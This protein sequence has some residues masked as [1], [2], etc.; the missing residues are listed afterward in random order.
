M[1]LH[2]VT[3]PYDPAGNGLA[4]HPHKDITAMLASLGATEQ[5]WDHFI[6]MIMFQLNSR[7]C[8]AI[9]MSPFLAMFGREPLNPLDFSLENRANLKLAISPAEWRKLRQT[10]LAARNFAVRKKRVEKKAG[11]ARVGLA[12]KVDN[13]VLLR[14]DPC[15][16][17][18]KSGGK[19]KGKWIGP[20]CVLSTS[21]GS[22]EISAVTRHARDW[23]LYFTDADDGEFIIR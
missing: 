18:V 2:S 16:A 17:S 6:P 3:A 10:H 9:G 7:F 20:F 19:F 5:D 4:E 15:F 12:A 21:C 1:I 13:L 22:L 8:K 23:K 11:K 14:V